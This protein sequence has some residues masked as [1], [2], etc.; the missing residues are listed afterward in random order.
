LKKNLVL[1]GM[2]ASGK[3]TIGKSL[4]KQLGMQFVDTDDVIEK[5]LSLSIAH[6]FEIK[7]ES[8]FREIEKE[9]SIKLA[10]KEGLVIALGGGA[11]MN[12]VVR[13]NIKKSSFSVWLDLNIDEIFKRAKMNKK[14]P[15]LNNSS[16]TNLKKLYEER[17]KIYSLADCKIDCNFKNKNEIVKEIKKLYENK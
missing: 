3:S 1:A 11:F 14:R 16:K 17:K 8:S 4:S 5:R 15:L 7:G 6:I 9:E 12:N 2:M 10:K 13:E